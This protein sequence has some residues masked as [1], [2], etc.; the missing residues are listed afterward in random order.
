MAR[1]RRGAG[2]VTLAEVAASAGVSTMT[3]SRF[4]NSPD[5]VSPAQ[6]ERIAQVVAETGYV[7]NQAAG[8]LASAHNRIV[9]M[10]VPNISG[11]IFAP[12]IQAFSDTLGEHG[13]QVLLASSYFSA[14]QEER[15]VRAFLGWAPAALVVTSHF[16]TEATERMLEQA[17]LPVLE[18]WD[19]RPER[20]PIQIGFSHYEVGVLAAE[21]VHARGYARPAFVLN[22]ATGDLSALERCQGFKDRLAQKGVGV[23]VHTPAPDLAPF[24]AGEQAMHALFAGSPP[25]DVIFFANDNLAAGGLLAAQHAGIRVPE[26][27]AVL[28]FGDYPFARMLMPRLTTIRPPAWAIGEQAAQRIIDMVEGAETRS[29]ATPLSCELLVRDSL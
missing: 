28:G 23:L 4:F 18:T 2:R 1:K 3:V 20:Q 21:A 14:E 8:G 17:A 13:Y 10:V 9:G 27:C 24:E 29:K 7:P 6:R 11:P 16:H 5:K 25:V 19:Y 26:Q 15:A 22:S 12:T